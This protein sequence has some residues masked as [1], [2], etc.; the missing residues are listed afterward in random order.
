MRKLAAIALALTSLALCGQ[1]Y[2]YI[3]GSAEAKA[4]IPVKFAMLADTLTSAQALD[5]ETIVASPEALGI[6]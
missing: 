6:N 5:A 2:A 3:Y 4:I 1:A